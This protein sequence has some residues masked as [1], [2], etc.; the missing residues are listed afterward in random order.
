MLGNETGS[1]KHRQK[2]KNKNVKTVTTQMF[3]TATR[4]N[5]ANRGGTNIG[6]NYWKS[7]L[8]R[9]QSN[10]NKMLFEKKKSKPQLLNVF[11]SFN[12]P[13]RRYQPC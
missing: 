5:N 7:F 13:C 4:M 6:T 8:K 10:Y 12:Q 11:S 2:T 1:G 3:C 9:I